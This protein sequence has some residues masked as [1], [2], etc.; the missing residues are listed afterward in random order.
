[1]DDCQINLAAYSIYV[2]QTH[3]IIWESFED[4]LSV[5]QRALLELFKKDGEIASYSKDSIIKFDNQI[6]PGFF[7]LMKGV[8]HCNLEEGCP[9]N[10][11]L[12]AG[13][14]IGL[15]EMLE[16]Q[17]FTCAFR[18][19]SANNM[20]MFIPKQKF[21]KKQQETPG[22][23]I[24]LIKRIHQEVTQLETRALNISQTTTEKRLF[25]ILDMLRGRLGY[26][27]ENWVPFRLSMDDLAEMIGASRNTL[28]RK[29]RELKTDGFI[30]IQDNHFRIV[31]EQLAGH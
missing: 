8:G 24:P 13:D 25:Y 17:K 27:K 29:L 28:V 19:D 30:E 1:V 2:E 3:T 10:Q 14:F 5:N 15:S 18:F 9:K 12:I 7:W 20:L 31:H 21:L 16:E 22:M 6:T 4:L 11:L 23:V 26:D